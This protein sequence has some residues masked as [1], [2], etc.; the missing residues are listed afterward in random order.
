MLGSIGQDTCSDHGVSLT[1]WIV[2]VEVVRK[3]FTGELFAEA[4]VVEPPSR[5]TLEDF[6]CTPPRS[7]TRL[8]ASSTCWIILA[9]IAG[10]AVAEMTTGIEIHYIRLRTRLLQ[11]R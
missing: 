4:A 8:G 11:D 6:A 7:S 5:P 1:F 3:E 9:Q 10:T 2:W